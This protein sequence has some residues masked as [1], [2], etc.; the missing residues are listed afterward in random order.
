[1]PRPKKCRWVGARPQTALFKPHGLPMNRLEQVDLAADELEAIRLADWENLSHEQAAEAM[2]ISRA[3][4]GR[5][6]GHARQCIADA[7]IHGKAIV[8][9]GG[10]VDYQPEHPCGRRRRCLTNMKA[11]ENRDNGSTEHGNLV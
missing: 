9:G 3:T 4:F 1:M 10:P 7:L 5:I 11:V 8:I 6:V 2:N